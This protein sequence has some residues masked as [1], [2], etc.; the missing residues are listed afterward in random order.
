MHTS[1]LFPVNTN[2]CHNRH[3]VT[4]ISLFYPLMAIDIQWQRLQRGCLSHLMLVG[5]T[6]DHIFMFYNMMFIMWKNDAG[7]VQRHL[8]L[9]TDYCYVQSVFFYMFIILDLYIF[10]ICLNI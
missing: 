8:T 3:F 5:N 9:H 2:F 1:V 6:E 7:T 4:A 10:W